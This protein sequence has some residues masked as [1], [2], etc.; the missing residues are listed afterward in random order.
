MKNPDEPFS[1]R[2]PM[3]SAQVLTDLDPSLTYY[4][5][6][7]YF[8][9]SLLQVSITRAL[10]DGPPVCSILFQNLL[11]RESNLQQHVCL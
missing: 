5:A 11:P 8:L 9:P 1:S 2:V 7:S 10:P 3:E 4:F 6:Q